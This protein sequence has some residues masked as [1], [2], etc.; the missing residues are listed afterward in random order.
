MEVAKEVKLL[1]YI[2]Q[3]ESLLYNFKEDE[4]YDSL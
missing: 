3:H 1:T 2:L 4:K